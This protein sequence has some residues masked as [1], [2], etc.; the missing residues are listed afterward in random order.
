[1]SSWEGIEPTIHNIS[2]QQDEVQHGCI[3]AIF[4]ATS[5]LTRRNSLIGHPGKATGK[6]LMSSNGKALAQAPSRDSTQQ[7]SDWFSAKRA[8]WLDCPI[9]GSNPLRPLSKMIG[10]VS[11]SK[12]DPVTMVNPTSWLS[13]Q[14][15]TWYSIMR[16]LRKTEA[17]AWFRQRSTRLATARLMFLS[18]RFSNN[19]RGQHRNGK[20]NPNLSE[21]AKRMT[22][23]QVK[24]QLYNSILV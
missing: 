19:C 18:N 13:T 2:N 8:V 7:R 6:S 11:R 9:G 12:H 17:K 21:E 22:E 3:K 10:R 20:P 15:L 24:A 4:W 23:S 1:M 14:C 16:P 5:G